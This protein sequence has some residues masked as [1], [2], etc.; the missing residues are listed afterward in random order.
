MMS[1]LETVYT[2]SFQNK[3]VVHTRKHRDW[4]TLI[5]CLGVMCLLGKNACQTTLLFLL[6][7]NITAQTIHHVV[8]P[9]W[10][11]GTPDC[12]LHI[13][14]APAFSI[15]LCHITDS[16]RCASHIHRFLCMRLLYTYISIPRRIMSMG[17][18]KM[19]IFEKS[20]ILEVKS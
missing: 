1:L 16:N 13:L 8:G 14:I 4:T 12:Y 7:V 10:L 2:K 15:L 18:F 20:I 9:L 17:H 19:T 5:P 6:Y 11:N 3:S